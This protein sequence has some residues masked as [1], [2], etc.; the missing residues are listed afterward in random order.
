MIPSFRSFC[1]QTSKLARDICGSIVIETAFVAPVLILMSV[2]SFEVSHMV[3][4]QHELQSGATEAE[5]VAL[6]ANLGLHTNTQQLEALLEDSLDL[7]DNQ[8]TITK[9]YRCNND[10]DLVASSDSCDGGNSGQGQ[11]EEHGNDEDIVVSTY[12]RLQFSDTY[13]PIW[14]HIGVAGNLEFSIDRTVQLS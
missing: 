8:L 9:L 12:I 13:T 7:E 14:A 11:D 3:A 5:A 1:A 10:S 4:R 2:G 6:A